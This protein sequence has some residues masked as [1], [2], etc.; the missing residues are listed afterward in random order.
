M[1]G[2]PPNTLDMERMQQALAIVTAYDMGTQESEFSEY[3]E[4]ISGHEHPEAMMHSLAQ[5]SW[6]LL[7]ALDSSPHLDKKQILSW[8]GLKFAEKGEELRGREE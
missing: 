5:F 4:M 7:R 1:S 2:R 6:L 8:Y 3:V